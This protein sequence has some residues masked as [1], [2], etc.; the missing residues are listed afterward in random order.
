[1]IREIEVPDG[2]RVVSAFSEEFAE[3]IETS[4]SVLSSNLTIVEAGTLEG[5]PMKPAI[6]GEW[7]NSGASSV[8]SYP[9]YVAALSRR[10]CNN[11]L[12][13]TVAESDKLRAAKK[14]RR[15]TRKRG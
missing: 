12:S 4:F 14:A 7:I 9:E 10:V 3:L 11:T 15:I 8:L 6:Y 1:M 2:Y 5:K 13:H